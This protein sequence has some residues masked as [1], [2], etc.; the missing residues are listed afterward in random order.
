MNTIH[1]TSEVNS[2]P[3]SGF[4]DQIDP[5]TYSN[6]LK[7]PGV[8]HYRLLAY[9]ASFV[10]GVVFDLGTYLGGSA[11]ALASYTKSVVLSFDVSDHLDPTIRVNLEA[12]LCNLV[13]LQMDAC[14][15][16]GTAKNSQLV[17]L[18][19]APHDGIQEQSIFD[20]LL[21]IG[22][23]GLLVCDD[24]YMN[25]AMR[26][27]WSALP[28]ALFMKKVDATKYGHW[29]G[30]GIVVFDQRYIDVEVK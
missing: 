14:L 4:E 1:I 5:A 6:M 30:T 29:S 22:F 15:A 3:F 20:T 28:M 16:A 7:E 11:L 13:F 27:W 26:N 17:F 19:V 21:R 25:D 23:R 24:I 8:E 10:S 2:I 18:D 9:L 12:R